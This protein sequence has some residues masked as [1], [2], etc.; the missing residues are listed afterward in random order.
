VGLDEPELVHVLGE[1]LEKP[2]AELGPVLLTTAEHD[3]DLHLVALLQEAD[4]VALLGLVVVGVDL[5]TKLH[6]LDDHVRLVA[7]RLASLLGVLVLELAVVHELADRRSRGRCDLDQVE[8]G[9][10][11]ESQGVVDADDADGLAVRAHE[12]DLGNPDPVVDAQ[13]RADV[14]SMC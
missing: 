13:L 7:T 9:L 6:L 2:E 5:G 10:L 8:V 1:S 3:R 14:S 11:R 4:D 12:T